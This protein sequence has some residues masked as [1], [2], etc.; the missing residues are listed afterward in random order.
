MMKASPTPTRR[1]RHVL[2]SG[3]YP[4]GRLP[5]Q[6]TR[7]AEGSYD[8]SRNGIPGAFA[9]QPLFLLDPG[10]WSAYALATRGGRTFDLYGTWRTTL[11]KGPKPADP[12]FEWVPHRQ[13]VL[14]RANGRRRLSAGR[15]REWLLE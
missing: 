11:R 2:R 7:F 1:L 9:L 13:Q 6:V 14:D 12:H 4:V 5:L 8:A 10:R 15:R 3:A